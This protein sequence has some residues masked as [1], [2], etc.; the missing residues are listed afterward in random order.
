MEER[1][2]VMVQAMITSPIEKAWKYWTEV[3]HIKKWY[4]AS[5]DWKCPEAE[6][7]LEVNGKFRFNLA[8]KDGETSFD[9]KGIYT[10]IIPEKLLKYKIEDG[11][12]VSVIFS[13][14]G[15]ETEIIETF[16]A[17]HFHTIEEQQSGWKAILHSFKYYC[18]NN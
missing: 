18:E 3:E 9:F 4:F 8:S 17:E 14:Q 7:N 15:T 12:I 16:E 5:D 6:N 13:L 10:E 1:K 11:R 2:K